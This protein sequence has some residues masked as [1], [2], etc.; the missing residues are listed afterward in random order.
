MRNDCDILKNLL[1]NILSGGLEDGR[2]R[3]IK[4]F[5]LTRKLN[6]L[7]ILSKDEIFRDLLGLSREILDADF[8]R[9]ETYILNEFG[10]LDLVR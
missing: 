8:S 7:K 4:K 2:I 5:Y 10:K 9:I 1:K 3:V 6:A